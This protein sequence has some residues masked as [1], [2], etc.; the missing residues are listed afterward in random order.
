MG[1][2]YESNTGG[3]RNELNNYCINVE[4]IMAVVEYNAEGWQQTQGGGSLF[5]RTDA[6]FVLFSTV[7]LTIFVK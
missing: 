7:L 1:A 6:I 3:G 5:R 4:S 2:G